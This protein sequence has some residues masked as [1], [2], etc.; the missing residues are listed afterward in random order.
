MMK[1]SNEAS[2]NIHL[3]P[4]VLLKKYEKEIKELKQELAMHDMLQSRGRINYEPYN[5]EEKFKQQEIAKKYLRGEIDDI[6]FESLRQVKEL[7]IQFR[8]LYKELQKDIQNN[9]V[10]VDQ[11]AVPVDQVWIKIFELN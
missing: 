7:F 8:N 2:V 6:E 4:H 5:A 3:D 9:N 11:K 10:V 1:V